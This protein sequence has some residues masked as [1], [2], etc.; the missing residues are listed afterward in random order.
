M[1]EQCDTILIV[2]DDP[3]VRFL[4]REQVLTSSDY[5]VVE[6]KD[7]PE[8]LWSLRQYFPDLIV[9]D[10]LLPGL[11][12]HDLLV[13]VQA[14]GFR[15]PLIAVAESGNP[16]AVVDAFRLGATDFVTKPLREAEVLAA[17][18]RGLADVR[19]RRQRDTL[20]SQLQQTNRQL[21]ARLRELTTLHE[22]GQS[23][24]T[25]RDLDSV[26]SHVLEGALVL[27]GAD[28]ALLLLR[29]DKSGQLVLR[30]GKNLPLALLDHLGEPVRDQFADLVMTSREALL[31][32]GDRLRRFVAARD[33]YAVA[34]VPLVVQKTAVGALA[35]GN[36]RTRAAFDDHHGRLLR[37][38]ADYAAITILS[39]RLSQIF[40]QRTN[41][42]RRT[43]REI[44]ERDAQRIQ[45]VS[46]LLAGLHQPLIAIE[47]ELIR[48]AQTTGQYSPPD[49]NRR[50]ATL[51]RQTRQ[52][53][54][55]V[56]A[57]RNRQGQ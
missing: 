7:G 15:G 8:A 36:S 25:L 10:L 48:L 31:V 40:E 23:V 27:T 43:Y 13:A 32:A 4:L 28:H 17:V 11:S 1:S 39:A 34:Y 57:L 42:L 44:Q 14:Q 47:A 33:L 56:N 6:A 52:L 16:R 50:L 55:H 45:Q 21:E 3:D 26:F 12:G 35:V 51:A 54:T 24:T 38:L 29:D 20:L 41:Q 30:A 19:M 2:D 46:D 22:I 37:S 5:Q 49:A 53:V 18:E 9:L